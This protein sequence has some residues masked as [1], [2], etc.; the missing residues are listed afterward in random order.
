M[1]QVATMTEIDRLGATPVSSQ[2]TVPS[3]WSPDGKL[4][5]VMGG[6]ERGRPTRWASSGVLLGGRFIWVLGESW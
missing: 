6:G 4:A 5:L 2:D 1:A 3:D